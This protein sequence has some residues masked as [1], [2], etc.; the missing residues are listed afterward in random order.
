MSIIFLALLTDGFG[1]NWGLGAQIHVETV[2]R[3]RALI[4]LSV[5]AVGLGPAGWDGVKPI[6]KG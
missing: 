3:K 5:F 6:G 2:L 1:S 4:F